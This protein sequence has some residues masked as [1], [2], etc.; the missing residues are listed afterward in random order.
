MQPPLGAKQKTDRA[1]L[2]DKVGGQGCGLFRLPGN[3]P[4]PMDGKI[5]LLDQGL[6]G[7]ISMG[8]AL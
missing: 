3:Q 4:V 1:G 6:T 5:G 2:I 8:M 7:A